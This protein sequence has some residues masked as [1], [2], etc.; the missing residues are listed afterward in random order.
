MTSRMSAASSHTLF[1]QAQY[2]PNVGGGLLPIAECQPLHVQADPPPSE[3]SPLSHF[4]MYISESLSGA[5]NFAD[6]CGQF[7]HALFLQAQHSPNVGG[8]LLP[9]AE[10]QS[11]HV[12]ADPPPS[13]ASPLPHFLCTSVSHCQAPMTS[14]MSAASSHALFLQAQQ[15]PNVGGGLL[16]I[17]GCQPLHVQ[18]DPPPSGASPLPHFFM[19]ISES[20]SGAHNFADVC[21]QF[22]RA[23]PPGTTQSKCERGL[24]PDSRV[25]VTAC[26]G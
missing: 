26:A 8:G 13:G 24:A 7:A 12:Q 20:L 3:A 25:S 9:I 4:F 19:Y 18:A 23:L 1:L 17:A 11:L 10:C 15:G 5:H 21:G 2:S 16:P 22:A 6:V 14:R